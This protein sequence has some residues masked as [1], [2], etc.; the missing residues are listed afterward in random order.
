[1]HTSPRSTHSYL[2]TITDLADLNN[3]RRQN[4]S[5]IEGR[6]RRLPAQ[7][8]TQEELDFLCQSPSLT[9]PLPFSTILT[10]STDKLNEEWYIEI[11]RRNPRTTRKDLLE[12]S[13][14]S[15]STKADWA[16]QIND[17]FRGKFPL[18]AKGNP[19]KQARFD[20]KDS[21]LMT[22][23]GRF[24]KLAIH[25]RLILD[26][27]WLSKLDPA[28]VQRLEAERDELENADHLLTAVAQAAAEASGEGVEDEA[29]D[30]EDEGEARSD[31]AE[32]G[33]NDEE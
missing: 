21:A 5:R 30:E 2:T 6:V 4:G 31:V 24:A 33:D 19:V 20:R 28:E 15:G 26:K 10:K 9:P 11:K 22:M 18:D 7:K 8:W 16:R 29:E 23:R 14:V 12:R 17:H 25:F 27:K 1:M 32:H 13:E 3:W